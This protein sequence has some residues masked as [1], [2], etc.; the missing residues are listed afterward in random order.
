MRSCIQTFGINGEVISKPYICNKIIKGMI[1]SE[2]SHFTP[3]RSQ[4]HDQ[5]KRNLRG[6]LDDKLF[7]FDTEKVYIMNW[8]DFEDKTDFD[9]NINAKTQ[10]QILESKP[11]YFNN[12]PRFCI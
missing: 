10:E 11:R 2:R 9:Q 4:P 1:M 7:I 12:F 3:Y 5:S 6:L 8:I